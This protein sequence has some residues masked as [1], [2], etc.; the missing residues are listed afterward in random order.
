[1]NSRIKSID[2]IRGL[3]IALMIVCNNPGTW[4]RMYPQLR[5]AVWH[6]VTL[7]DFAFPF[8]YIF[9]CYNSNINK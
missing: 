9:R 6:G 7:A 5:H 3:S 8:C 2:I 1:M 4:M